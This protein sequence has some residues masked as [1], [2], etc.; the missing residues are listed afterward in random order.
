MSFVLG[1]LS[2]CHLSLFT[3]DYF[4]ESDNLIAEFITLLGT[5]DHFAFL[6]LSGGKGRDGLMLVG[7][8]ISVL[9]PDGVHVVLVEE[10]EELL[11][12]E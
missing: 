4:G 2:L 9:R 6:L 10:R 11:L 1:T 12:D 3:D 8:E 7:I 5:I